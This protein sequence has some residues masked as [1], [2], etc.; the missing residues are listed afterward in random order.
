MGLGPGHP[1]SLP[2][3]SPFY[4]NSGLRFPI[5]GTPSGDHQSTRGFRQTAPI[6]KTRWGGGFAERSDCSDEV[7]DLVGQENGM[8]L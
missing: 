6:S 4:P 7:T 8:C 1:K 2:S 3:H 5:W